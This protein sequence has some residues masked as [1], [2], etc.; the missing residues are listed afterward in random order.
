[1]AL[2]AVCVSCSTVRSPRYQT[3]EAKPRIVI[4]RLEKAIHERI[5]DERRT[6][7]LPSLAWDDGLAAIARG[8]SRDMAVRGYFDHYSPDGGG[9]SLRYRKA[10]YVCEQRYG[11]TVFQGAEN[12]ALNHLYNA[13]RTVNGTRFYDWNDEEVL[14]RTTV[15]G[16]MDSTGHRKNILAPAYRHEGVGIFIT[17]T[18]DVYITQNFC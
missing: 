15:Q 13:I 11:R 12:I 18:G 4:L 14:A 3:G 17:E 6:H 10:G 2:C 1:M 9:F 5:N 8:H 16:W 7:G